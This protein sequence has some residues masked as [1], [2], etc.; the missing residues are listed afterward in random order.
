[1]AKKSRR[2]KTVVV[3]SVGI[4]LCCIITIVGFMGP[5]RILTTRFELNRLLHH[6]DHE[7]LLVACRSLMKPEFVGTYHLR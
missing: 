7:L 6:T 3:S 5:C 4:V 1:M 2:V